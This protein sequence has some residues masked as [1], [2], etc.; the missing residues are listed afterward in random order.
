MAGSTEKKLGKS[1]KPKSKKSKKKIRHV[2][3]EPATDGGGFMA[4]HSY[5]PGEPDDSG[6]SQQEPDSTHALAD[7]NALLQHVQDHFG[8]S[9]PQQAPQTGAAGPSDGGPQQSGM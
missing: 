1:S 8:G 5:E 9:L 2:H 7:N 6:M 3:I 4:R